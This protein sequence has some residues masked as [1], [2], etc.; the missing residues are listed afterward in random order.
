MGKCNFAFG[1][2]LRTVCLKDGDIHT[3]H[4]KSLSMRDKGRFLQST[5]LIAKHN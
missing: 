5:N 1:T 4:C 2:K 3:H